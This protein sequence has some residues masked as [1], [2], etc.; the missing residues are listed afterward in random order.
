MTASGGSS[1]VAKLNA[2][3]FDGRGLLAACRMGKSVA[4]S[5]K[6]CFRA[7]TLARQEAY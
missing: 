5:P 2:L 3:P 6:P 1:V 7:N 4:A